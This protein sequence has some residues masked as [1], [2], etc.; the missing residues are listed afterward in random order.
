MVRQIL[1]KLVDS[2]FKFTRQVMSDELKHEGLKTDS[3]KQVKGPTS[4]QWR[5]QRWAVGR[6]S[7]LYASQTRAI[8]NHFS[9][10]YNVIKLF[11]SFRTIQLV[12]FHL[13]QCFE[14]PYNQ[15]YE[16]CAARQSTQN[17]KLHEHAA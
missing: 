13:V 9:A 6:S 15:V 7:P 12:F 8:F 3:S 16:N 1:D 2:E 11:L 4:Y 5:I 17:Y 14:Q 10:I